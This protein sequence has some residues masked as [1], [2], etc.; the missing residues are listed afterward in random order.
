[1]P[2]PC[3]VEPHARCYK[4]HTDSLPDATALRRG[5]S[6]SPLPITKTQPSTLPDATALRRGVSRSPLPE[7]SLF[8]AKVIF[9]VFAQPPPLG[10]MA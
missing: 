6:R 2:R 4:K 8:V 5:V 10:N 7:L 3:A 9:V 1:M